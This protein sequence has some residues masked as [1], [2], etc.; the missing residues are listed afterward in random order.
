[1]SSPDETARQDSGRGRKPVRTW[2]CG[3]LPSHRSV[4]PTGRSAIETMCLM[5]PVRR[6]RTRYQPS[7]SPVLVIGRLS[8]HERPQASVRQNR[9]RARALADHEHHAAW[10]AHLLPRSRSTHDRKQTR[11]LPWERSRRT[12]LALE[13]QSQH[14]AIENGL[15]RLLDGRRD[16][17]LDR[18]AVL[19]RSQAYKCDHAESTGHAR[20]ESILE[21]NDW[22]RSDLGQPC[23]RIRLSVLRL[24][25]T[26]DLTRRVTRNSTSLNGPRAWRS[27][28]FMSTV[29]SSA[30]SR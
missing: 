5:E 1:M 24:A 11:A 8:R 18:S 30:R 16:R 9:S 23:S 26:D 13:T 29:V 17:R 20:S 22:P 12:P 14:W 4:A 6:R 15:L 28:A 19:P 25:A 27:A 2:R 7:R 3:P 10:Q 21:P